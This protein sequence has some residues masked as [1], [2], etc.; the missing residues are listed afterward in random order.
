MDNTALLQTVGERASQAGAVAENALLG[1]ADF[2]ADTAI[3]VGNLVQDAANSRRPPARSKRR[4]GLLFGIL[5]VSGALLFLWKRRSQSSELS[6]DG[7]RPYTT[8]DPAYDQKGTDEAAQRTGST[9]QGTFDP[10]PTNSHDPSAL[11]EGARGMG[12]ES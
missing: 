7:M 2:V 8:D 1:V 5:I 3:E 10:D 4:F 6:D 11:H 12:V 9:G